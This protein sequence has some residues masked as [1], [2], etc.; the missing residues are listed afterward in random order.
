MVVNPHICKKG[1]CG[2]FFLQKMK[3]KKVG[4]YMCGRN[5]CLSLNSLSLVMVLLDF[6]L[7]ELSRV[8]SCSLQTC[9]LLARWREFER[10]CMIC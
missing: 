2:F 3:C 10:C 1:G 5:S 6:V 9:T 4:V 7:N 8:L